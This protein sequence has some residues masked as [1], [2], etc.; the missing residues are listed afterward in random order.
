MRVVLLLPDADEGSPCAPA[1]RPR[2]GSTPPTSPRRKWAFENNRAA[3]RGADT[4]PGAQRLFLPLRTGARPGRRRRPRHRAARGRCSPPTQ[5]RLLDAL[6]DQARGGDRARQPRRGRRAA[7]A[8]GRDR[9]AAPALLTS[10][11]HDLRTPLASILGAGEHAARLRRAI[12]TLRRASEL[13]GTIQEEAE[14]LNRF[15]ANL[16]DMT[17]LESGAVAPTRAPLDLARGRRQ[18]ACSAPASVLADHGVDDRP[19]RRP[20]DAATSTRCCSSRCCSTCSTTR[21]N[22]P[23]AGDRRSTASRAAAATAASRLRVLDEGDGIPPRRARAHLRQVPPRP[24]GRPRCRA[25]TGPRPRHLP[26]LRRGDGRDASS[27]ATGR[28]RPGA[29]FTIAL[30]VPPAPPR[31]GRRMTAPRRAHPGR[32]RRAGDPPLAAHQPRRAGLRRRWRRRPAAEAW[33]ALAGGARPRGPRPRPAGHRRARADPR[34]ARAAT[35]GAD[36][37]AVEPQR[38]ARQGRGA[39]PRR[40]RLRDQALRHATSCWRA[41]R[42]ALRHRLQAQG[43]RPVFRIG[44]LA[45]DLVRRI[46][47]SAA[48]RSSCR[49]KEYDILRLLVQHAGKVLTHRYLMREVWGGRRRRAVSARLCPPAPPEDRARPRAADATS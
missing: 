39:R 10:I 47:T 27:P 14:R 33:R 31:R 48:R 21:R 32:R 24:A 38:R 15:I 45:V 26:R 19:R 30:P 12:S 3:G 6:A 7:R 34:A 41:L 49:R 42:A 40:R 35:G 18:R 46:V 36:H 5:R 1:I 20:A 25:G 22:T 2:T 9:A 28:D 17:R 44:D 16:L 13:L 8:R 43:E 4:L 11:S 23:P 29:V 37:R